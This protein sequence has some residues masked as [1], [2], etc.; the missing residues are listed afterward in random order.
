MNAPA[1]PWLKHYPAGVRWDAPIEQ[2]V[3]QALLSRAVAAYAERPLFEYRGRRISYW[4]FGETAAKAAA[5][6]IELGV[7]KA[8]RSRFIC[9]IRHITPSRFSPRCAPV[10]ASS[11]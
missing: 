1:H 8:M 11:T 4:Q 9:Q 7:K 5:G 10:R 3:V 6:L 2:T